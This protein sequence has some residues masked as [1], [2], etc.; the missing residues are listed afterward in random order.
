M[1]NDDQNIEKQANVNPFMLL[2]LV[3]LGGGITG[4]GLNLLI[5]A[6][7]PDRYTG[8]MAARDWESQEHFNDE[9]R[10]EI[11]RLQDKCRKNEQLLGIIKFRFDNGVYI[12]HQ[13]QPK[14]E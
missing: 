12:P 9:I 4:G 2:V 6:E 3:L 11:N 8:N 5:P 7:A 13:H 10:A 1:E 14:R